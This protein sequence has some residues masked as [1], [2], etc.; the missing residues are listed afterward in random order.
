MLNHPAPSFGRGRPRFAAITASG[1]AAVAVGGWLLP[2]AGRDAELFGRGVGT[3]L[4]ALTAGAGLVALLRRRV[5]ALER[6]RG[7]VVQASVI[8]LEHA[9]ASDEAHERKGSELEAT[10]LHVLERFATAAEYRMDPT[11]DHTGR[12]AEM[13]ADLANA[14]GLDGTEVELIRRAAPLHD[15]GNVAVPDAILLK[16]GPLTADEL[17]QMK[18]HTIVGD[19]ILARHDHPVLGRAKQIARSHHESWDGTGYPLG[20]SR[21]EIP[22]AGRI[23]AVVDA[24]DALTSDRPHR[25][26][27]TA[28]EALE[29]IADQRGRRFD[30]ELTD[31]FLRMVGSRSGVAPRERELVAAAPAGEMEKA[32]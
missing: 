10:V 23:V 17:E 21:A 26:A 27:W 12:V 28:E 6:A 8:A 11:G 30:P 19:Q 31:A 1:L 9:A 16:P 3:W 5:I 18:V 32:A 29:E 15:V 13:A 14:I 20:L 22:L 4:L 25:E 24:F 7:E 2:L